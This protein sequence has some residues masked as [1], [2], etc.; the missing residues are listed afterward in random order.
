M[1][2]TVDAYAMIAAH[3][4]A[5]VIA[6]TFADAKVSASVRANSVLAAHIGSG[7]KAEAL[8]QA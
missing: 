7:I 1:G 5:H 3:L 4:A 6:D 2:V 8:L